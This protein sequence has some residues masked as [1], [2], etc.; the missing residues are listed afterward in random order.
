VHLSQC[1]EDLE[2]NLDGIREKAAEKTYEYNG[3]NSKWREERDAQQ[4]IFRAFSQKCEYERK[5]EQRMQQELL[6]EI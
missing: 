1:L 3:E 2:G 5:H 6:D 4:R